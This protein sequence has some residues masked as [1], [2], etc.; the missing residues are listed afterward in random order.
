MNALKGLWGY[1]WGVYKPENLGVAYVQMG[2]M[3]TT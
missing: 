1:D 2:T 3:R